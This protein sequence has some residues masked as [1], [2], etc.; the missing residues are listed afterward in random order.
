VY[1][2]DIYL[3]SVMTSEI[4]QMSPKYLWNLKFDI[5]HFPNI[6]HLK[7]CVV[8]T[9][10]LINQILLLFCKIESHIQH[11]VPQTICFSCHQ[12]FFNAYVLFRTMILIKQN[13]ILIPSNIFFLDIIEHRKNISVIVLHF[14]HLLCMSHFFSL[15]LSLIVS[16]P[17]ESEDDN[18]FFLIQ[19]PSDV[20]T[21]S[22]DTDLDTLP[23]VHEKL[24]P[25]HQFGESTRV[26]TRRT[27]TA[28]MHHLL[29]RQFLSHK[30]VRMFL[31]YPLVM[32]FPLLFARINTLIHLILFLVLY[33]IH[34]C[35][36]PIMPLVL[37]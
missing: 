13:W 8:I 3:L 32:T 25:P 11:Y 21:P 2:L 14:D 26:F 37:L 1:V 4:Q 23:L 5:R 9:C 33:L 15:N 18:I 12:R 24:K 20:H 31:H 30:L 17:P 36:P 16:L 10:Y 27:S 7:H 19:E 34:T 35:P 28:P 22:V 6:W 29:L